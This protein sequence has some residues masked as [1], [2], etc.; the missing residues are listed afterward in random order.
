[1]TT[2]NTLI[3][4]NT[5]KEV[6]LEKCSKLLGNISDFINKETVF[7]VVQEHPSHKDALDNL[8]QAL[9]LNEEAFVYLQSVRNLSADNWVKDAVIVTD[10]GVI[11]RPSF[12]DLVGKSINPNRIRFFFV[13]DKDAVVQ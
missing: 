8:L 10:R 12:Y 1:M 9:R 11:N 4:L 6:P 13:E 5:T 7:V 3:L 2:L